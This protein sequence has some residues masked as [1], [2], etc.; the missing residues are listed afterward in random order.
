MPSGVRSKCLK[1]F[2]GVPY[3]VNEKRA[4]KPRKCRFWRSRMYRKKYPLFYAPMF[5]PYPPP[6]SLA[7]FGF[8]CV[9]AVLVGLL[10]CVD[11]ALMLR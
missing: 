6:P 5:P 8:C 7:P 4:C 1:L 3:R 10:W 9:L 11:A 2:L